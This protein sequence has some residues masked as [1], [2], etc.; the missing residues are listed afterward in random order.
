MIENKAASAMHIWRIHQNGPCDPVKVAS[1]RNWFVWKMT[2]SISS[3][4]RFTPRSDTMS[5]MA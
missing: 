2:S 5:A 3:S 1:V 4:R